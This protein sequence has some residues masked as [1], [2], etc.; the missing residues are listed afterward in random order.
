MAEKHYL[1]ELTTEIGV[2]I[3]DKEVT[4]TKSLYE[5]VMDKVQ[6]SID[7]QNLND[8]DYQVKLLAEGVSK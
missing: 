6:L 4:E 3:D 5:L 2:V 1:V 7:N 8:K